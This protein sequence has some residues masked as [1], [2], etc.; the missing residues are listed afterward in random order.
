MV[1]FHLDRKKGQESPVFL[2]LYHRGKRIKV[3]TGKKIDALK[4]DLKTCRANPRKFKNN[5]IGFNRFLQGISDEVEKALNEGNRITK[6]DIKSIIDKANG[7][8]TLDSFYGFA[9][10]YLKRQLSKGELKPISS[11]GYIT[12]INH[13]KE[14]NPN[15]TFQ[16]VS[17]DFYDKFVA[18][19]KLKGLAINSIGAN[20]KR[21]K[22]FMA[23]GF[24]RDK[25]ANITFRKKAFR[26]NTEETDQIYLTPAEITQFINCVLPDKLKKVADAFVINCYFG[27]RFSDMDQIQG[28]N[29]KKEDELYYLYMIQG[30]GAINV[31]IP[32]PEVALKLL[33]KYE[34]NCPVLNKSGK[35]ISSQKFNSY[36]KEAARVA[37]LNEMVSI[38]DGDKVKSLPKHELIVSHTSRRSFST[39][40]YLQGVPIQHI[41][42]VTGH[43]KESTF[44]LYVRADQLTKSKG[45]A[46]HYIDK[47]SKATK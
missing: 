34:F 38:R 25:H 1:K 47:A 10:E 17:L 24:D 36:L 11:K 19:L 22:W 15:L 16:D 31:K 35:L 37:E 8:T 27:M 42:A 44:M 6:A 39:N 12:T 41:M 30:K 28:K 13:L 43:K 21:L 40:L 33:M 46:K 23:A 45:L 4:W 32:V 26:A 2:G 18:Y 29:F 5:A 9:D 20:I 7:K 14:F 3:F